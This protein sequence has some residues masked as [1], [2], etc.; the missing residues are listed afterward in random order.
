MREKTMNRGRRAFTLIELLVVI[1]IIAVLLAIL[2][3]VVSRVRQTAAAAN[4]ASEMHRISAAIGN[5]FNDFQAYPG[6]ASN[7]SFANGAKPFTPVSGNYTQ[8]EDLVMALLGGLQYDTNK[9][10]I[11]VY[12]QVGLGPTS[13]NTA[14]VSPR[15]N[16]YIE[17]TPAELTPLELG[18]PVPMNM[19]SDLGKPPYTSDSEVPEFMDTFTMPRSILYIRANP[20]AT[21]GNVLYNGNSGFNPT[22]SYDFGQL[23]PYLSGTD[24][25][26]KDQSDATVRAYFATPDTKDLP[27]PTARAA[28]TYLLIDAGPDRIFGNDDDIIVS[29]GG[30]Q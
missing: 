11:L 29:A 19:V 7:Q 3:P 28:G 20:S 21:R 5:Y 26:G 8:S 2:I 18:K 15:K 9:K 14:V 4:V 6:M 27:Q 23:K 24:F 10:L 25:G 16:A 17:K 22:F 12:D 13:L 30:G 1:G